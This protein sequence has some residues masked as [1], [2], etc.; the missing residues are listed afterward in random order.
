MR[1]AYVIQNVGNID[2]TKDVGD[3]VPVKNTL[4]GL[5]TAGYH[6]DCFKLDHQSVICI[7]DVSYPEQFFEL[8]LGLSGSQS[9]RFLEGGF[10]RLQRLLGLPYSAFIDSFRFYEGCVRFLPDYDICHEHNGLFS[11]GA[12]YASSQLGIPYILTFSADPLLELSLIGK[13]LKGIHEYI[14]RKEAMFSYQLAERIICVSEQAKNHLI[15]NWQVMPDKICVMPNGVDIE[16][17]GNPHDSRMIRSEYD[18]KDDFVVGFVGGFQYWHGLE[19]LLESFNM[20]KSNIPNSTLLL[21]GDGPVRVDIET[22]AKEMDLSNSVIITGLV[23]QQRVPEL[24]SA[25]DLAVL[26]YPQL[27]KDLWFSPLK[28]YEYMAAGKAI[29]AS[30]SGQISDV[31]EDG[32]NGILVNPGDA[33]DLANAIIHLLQDP[34]KR[35]FLGQNARRKAIANHSWDNYIGRLEQIYLSV[36]DSSIASGRLSGESM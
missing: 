16:L 19:R 21:V 24:M 30:D 27:P 33:V 3:T 6:A 14:A 7:E 26:P 35:V 1:L 23:P 11:I 20:V 17:F 13:P 9:F 15:D 36:L 32:Y 25:M 18:L 10:R 8:P 31:I 22:M 5:Q 34:L 2:F 29:V 28:L 12:S 4:L